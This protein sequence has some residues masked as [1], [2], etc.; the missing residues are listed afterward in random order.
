[1]I[2][3]MCAKYHVKKEEATL[4]ADFLTPMLEVIPQKRMTSWQALHHP[5]LYDMSSE[6]FEVPDPELRELP[7]S[8]EKKATLA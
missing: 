4:L 6:F 7:K 5:W 1:M 3:L 2:D 8:V